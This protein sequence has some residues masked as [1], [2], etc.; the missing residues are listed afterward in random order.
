MHTGVL[1]LHCNHGCCDI[2]EEWEL[3]LESLSKRCSDNDD[4]IDEFVI[5]ERVQIDGDGV[6]NGEVG[7]GVNPDVICR[8]PA[9][10]LPFHVSMQCK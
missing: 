3:A 8:L 1:D 5:V 4:Q 7:G 6:N 2:G 9:F 10:G